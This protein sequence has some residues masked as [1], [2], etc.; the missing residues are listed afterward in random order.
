MK[1]HRIHTL[2]PAF[3]LVLSVTVTNVSC[4]TVDND[5][6]EEYANRRAKLFCRLKAMAKANP[7]GYTVDVTTLQHLTRGYAVAVAGTQNCFNDESLYE[8]VD[9][10]MAHPE[11]NA[12]GG[13][14]DTMTGNYHYDATMIIADRD[15]AIAYGKKNGQKAIFD[16]NTMSEIMLSPYD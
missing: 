16:L 3:L 10:V 2:L 11:I 4:C 7:N 9:Y 12:Y 5:P 15:E 14:L 13:W 6:T 8:V 1:I